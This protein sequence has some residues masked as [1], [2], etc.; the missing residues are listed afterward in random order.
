V[1]RGWHKEGGES[2]YERGDIKKEVDIE[3]EKKEKEGQES[4]IL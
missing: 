3:K 2:G 4:T 1:E